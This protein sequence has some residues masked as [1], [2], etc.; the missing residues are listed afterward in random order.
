MIDRGDVIPELGH[1]QWGL[2]TFAA[3]CA[4]L[5]KAGFAGMGLVAV[6][7]FADIFGARDST[8]VVLPLLIAADLGAVSIYRQHA[9]WDYIRRTWPAAAVGVVIGALLLSRLNNASFRPILGTIILALTIAQLARMFRTTAPPALAPSRPLALTLG[10]LAG[11]TTM[12]ANAA[13][14]LVALYFVAVGLP[15]FEVVGTLAWFFFLINLFKMPFSAGIGVVHPETLLLDAILV[16]AVL[17]GLF[18]GRWLIH[19]IPQR[20]FDI[21]MLLF[22]GLASIRLIL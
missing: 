18:A 7:V 6:I 21:L 14:P 17:V 9:R 3:I 13:G 8:G 2:A 22:A 19:R 16:P 15:K 1:L 10:L 20:G 11:I 12:M 5:S 4:G